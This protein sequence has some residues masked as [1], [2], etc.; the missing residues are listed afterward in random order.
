MF[1]VNSE[2][3]SL[4]SRREAIGIAVVAGGLI[5]AILWGIAQYVQPAPPSR[6]VLASGVEGGL[7]H[8]YALRYKEILARDGVTVEER[9]TKGARENLQLLEDPKSGV[10]VAFAQA[11]IATF[12]EADG[13]V[14]LA[15]LYYE[16]LW[17]FTRSSETLTQINQL[18]GKR[19]ATGI[20]GSGTRAFLEPLL[21]AN[22]V[23]SNNAT[24]I[25]MGGDDAMRALLAGE[26]DVA[27]F[28]GGPDVQVIRAAMSN[29][30]LRVMSLSRA[31]AYPRR[32]PYITKLTMP[33]G[34]MDLARNEPDKEIVMI[35][36]QAMLAARE[37]IHPA[38]INLLLDAAHEIHSG[39]GYFEAAGEFPRTDR[40][41]LPCRST[42]TGTSI[43]GRASCTATCRSGSPH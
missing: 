28:V 10:D 29:T 2:S 18:Q 33:P 42:R 11:G 16:P 8:R 3:L 43:S 37:G 34:T 27:A 1:G 41:D 32:F 31:D 25:P 19:I 12:P 26:V 40:I 14:M 36:T 13:L 4:L 15:S 7:Y 30:A 17:L 38:L 22:R 35:S 21:R 5:A 39:Q 23:T 6:I 20:E 9:L 24:L